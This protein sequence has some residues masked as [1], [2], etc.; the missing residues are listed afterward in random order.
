MYYI[1]ITD[2]R[3]IALAALLKEHGKQ[4][5][6]FSWDKQIEKNSTCIF[7]PSKKF[8]TE[9]AENLLNDIV[10]YA[11]ALS[12]EVVSILNNKNIIYH[13]LMLDEV[14]TI[15]NANLTCEGVLALILEHSDKSIYENNI[16]ILGGG[17][18]TKAMAVLL[19]RLGV[20]FAIVSFN[21]L[22]FP[23][24]YLYSP[25][26][27]FGYLFV[28]DLNNFDII[29]NTIPANIINK[30]VLAKIAP[31]TIFIETASVNCL[32]KEKVTN[33]NYIEAPGLPQKYSAKTAG[34]L[35]F[36]NILGENIYD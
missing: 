36:E 34:K 24:Y 35:M 26:C 1:D 21:K 31:N 30:E 28:E 16:L 18:I 19:N 3:N 13:N 10:L 27:Y 33:F 8:S 22:K 2:K 17:R 11:G 23:E 7:S 4:V 25:K 14:F 29:V 15:K 32:N 9:M 5:E 12:S 6:E 20:K